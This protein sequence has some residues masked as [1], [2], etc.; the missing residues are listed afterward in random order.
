MQNRDWAGPVVQITKSKGVDGMR[1]G[2][3]I[4]AVLVL[5]ISIM[6]CEDT[7]RKLADQ[8]SDEVVNAAIAEVENQG[9][10]AAMV[11]AGEA[12]TLEVAGD[13]EIAGTKVVIPA[14][15]IP[16]TVKNAWLQI[17]PAGTLTITFPTARR[18]GPA[19]LIDLYEFSTNADITLTKDATVTVVISD[20]MAGE[21]EPADVGVGHLE[22][23]TATDVTILAGASLDTD[24]LLVSGKTKTFSPFMAVVA[25]QA[26][27]GQAKASKCV[28]TTDNISNGAGVDETNTAYFD[29]AGKITRAVREGSEFTDEIFK[30]SGND[31]TAIERYD[32][33]GSLVSTR[34]V[35]WERDSSNHVT[36][37][38]LSNNHQ[39]MVYFYNGSGQITQMNDLTF[40]GT[41]EIQYNS[42]GAIDRTIWQTTYC[43]KFTYNGSGNLTDWDEYDGPCPDVN[44]S[45]QTTREHDFAD[46]CPKKYVGQLV[47]LPYN[48]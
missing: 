45:S 16:S 27:S 38:V 26:S 18:I 21:V 37:E 48:P 25:E 34:P 22:S 32:D 7:L 46:P 47:D 20:S 9:G 2:T 40:S 35:T 3:K 44:P 43:D 8:I 30:Y 28:Y 23:S 10:A 19:A 15:A 24:K 6:A 17:V 4:L 31:M 1:V 41:L 39:E 29:A 42:D 33:Q 13:S 5:P 12:L 14:G 11:S 36:R